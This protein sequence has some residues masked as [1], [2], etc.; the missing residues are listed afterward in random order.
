MSSLPS[1]SAKI[2]MWQTPVSKGAAHE[3]DALGLERGARRGHVVAAQ[4]PRVALLGNERHPLLLGLPDPEAGVAGPLLP[5][6]VR[7]GAQPQDAAVERSGALG[8]L[9]GDAEEVESFDDSHSTSR[10]RIAARI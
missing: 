6:G 8:V 3:L 1:G 5:L 7:V 10:P 2:A 4:R 9:G